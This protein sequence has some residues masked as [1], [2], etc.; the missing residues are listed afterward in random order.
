LQIL[1]ADSELLRYA[2]DADVAPRLQ[3]ARG[4]HFIVHTADA[5]GGRLAPEDSVPTPEQMPEMARMPA[6]FNPLTGPV[7]IS[8]AEPGDTVV[9]RIIRVEPAAAGVTAHIEGMGQQWSWR[10][11][12]LF[13]GPKR[14]TVQHQPGPSGS[15]ADGT[16]E[17]DGYHGPLAPMVGTIGVAPEYVPRSSRGDQSDHGGVWD[18]P[19]VT[20][21]TTLY[22][23]VY[24]PG[25]LLSL[26]DMHA[27]QGDCEFF[28]VA[29]EVPGEVELVCDVIKGKTIPYPRLETADRLLQ[30]Y[31]S[32]PLE[33]AVR[34]ATKLLMEWL[35][36]DFGVSEKQAYWLVAVNPE[37]RI[38][39]GL[40][41]ATINSTVTAE[42]TKASVNRAGKAAS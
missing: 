7:F 22:F 36:G 13:D 8:G 1:T 15:Y 21:G 40:L 30:I 29:D 14:F 9:V 32:R 3:V 31:A 28:G 33:E 27:V 35:V 6:R 17:V 2:F 23:P 5:F 38:T 19:Y 39:I 10:N 11:W 37:F 42:I 34:S 24:H 18:S 4:E 16:L 41:A 20:A 12:K 26:G 25:A